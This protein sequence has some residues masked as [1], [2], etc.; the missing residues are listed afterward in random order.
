M[1]NSNW[2]EGR[3]RGPA[4]VNVDTVSTSKL[5]TPSGVSAT[6]FVRGAA[7]L[8]AAPALPRGHAG[9]AAALKSDLVTP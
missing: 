2:R 7:D 6:P 3:R 8:V 1:L 5:P 4:S 9:S